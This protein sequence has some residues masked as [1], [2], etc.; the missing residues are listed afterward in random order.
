MPIQMPL[1]PVSPNE[2]RGAA[3]ELAALLQQMADEEENWDEAKKEHKQTVEVLKK[4]IT[5][6]RLVIRRAQLEHEEGVTAA[7]VNALLDEA[8]ERGDS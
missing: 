2:F 1:I 3:F 5:E 4:G 6:Q 7:Q 8:Q